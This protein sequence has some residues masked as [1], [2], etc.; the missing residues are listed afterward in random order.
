MGLDSLE[1]KGRREGKD[2]KEKE[3]GIKSS[4]P[5]KSMPVLVRVPKESEKNSE[6]K[7]KSETRNQKLKRIPSPSL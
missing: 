5:H 3:R 2:R 1:F 7:Q 6:R 4:F